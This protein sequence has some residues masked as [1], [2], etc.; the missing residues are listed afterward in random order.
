MTAANLNSVKYLPLAPEHFADVIRLGNEVQ[1]ENYLMPDTLKAMYDKSW[2]NNINASLVSYCGNDIVPT[3]IRSGNV[4]NGAAQ[5]FGRWHRKKYAIS[6]AI[7]YRLLCKEWALE[8]P[9]W[10]S[11]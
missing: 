5:N 9:Y 10:Q 6:N 4:I 11:R 7:R 8:V 1:G 2:H 3:L